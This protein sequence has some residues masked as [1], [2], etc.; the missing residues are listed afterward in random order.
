MSH[1]WTRPCFN[2]IGPVALASVKHGS[3][4][5]GS[6]CNV[7]HPVALASVKHGSISG[8]NCTVWW[9][10]VPVPL[11]RHCS[12]SHGASV[13][14]IS[15]G[16]SCSVAAGGHSHPILLQL[17]YEILNITHESNMWQLQTKCRRISSSSWTGRLVPDWKEMV[18][19][20]C[21][22]KG[23]SWLWV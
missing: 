15:S 6:S 18:F 8:G 23:F 16:D 19:C 2:S 10:P 12:S 9:H 14:F 21:L 17:N 7:G 13:G 11:S 3:V 5:S 4:T 20:L 1:F 22:R